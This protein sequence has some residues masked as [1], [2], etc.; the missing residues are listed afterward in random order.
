MTREASERGFT[1]AD[2]SAVESA[3]D[4][5]LKEREDFVVER[6]MGAIGP[7]MGVV[8]GKLGGSADGKISYNVNYGNLQDEGFTP[9]NKLT[10]DA[11]SF[12]GRAELSN[13]FTVR[14]TLNYTNTLFKAPPISGGGGSSPS[15]SYTHLTL[16]TIYSV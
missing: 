9:G 4:E 14:G 8:M 13:K 10:R 1:P 2:N 11:I 7:L 5:V 16:P 6:G 15:V 12:G 3:V